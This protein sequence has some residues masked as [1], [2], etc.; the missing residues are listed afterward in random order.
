VRIGSTAAPSRRGRARSPGDHV[1]QIRSGRLN[2]SV[3]TVRLSTIAP[4]RAA[5]EEA[6]SA[7]ASGRDERVASARGRGFAEES[8]ASAS[9]R[10]ARARS[11]SPSE[12][13]Q[14]R[15]RVCSQMVVSLTAG[16]SRPRLLARRVGSTSEHKQNQG[17]NRL[18]TIV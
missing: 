6:D 18:F 8:A 3:V 14:A 12:G 7:S 13:M 10:S 1:A 4:P 15:H 2:Q 9:G 11:T 5:E 16:T 17:R